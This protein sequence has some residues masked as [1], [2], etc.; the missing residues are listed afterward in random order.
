MNITDLSATALSA[1]IHD[2]RVS[3]R[4][5]MQAYLARIAEVNPT[6]NAIVSLRDGDELVREADACDAELAHGASRGWM[7][8]MPQAIKDMAP[9][10]GLRTTQGSPLLRDF[11]PRNDGLMVHRMKAAGCIVIAKTNTPEFGLVICSHTFYFKNT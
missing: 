10:R 11:I 4:E 5:V 1:A 9:T 3:C 2:K 6:H 7:H 8:G